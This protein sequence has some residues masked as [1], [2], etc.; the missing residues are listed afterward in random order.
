MGAVAVPVGARATFR[1]QRNGWRRSK[2]M[3]RILLV[4][5][6]ALALVAAA[7]AQKTTDAAAEARSAAAAAWSA[8]KWQ[9]ASANYRKVVEHDPKD[10]QAWHRLG[11]ALHA[12]GRL[13]EALQAHERTLAFPA[14]APTGAYNAACVYALKG[15]KDKAFEWLEKSVQRG[16]NNPQQFAGDRD[17]DSL[18]DD[19]RYAAVIAKV[20]ENAS[21]EQLQVFAQ[22]TERKRNRLV[23]FA[24]NRSPGQLSVEYGAVPWQAKFAAMVDDEST[25][26]RKWRLGADFWT[27]LDTSLPMT[28]GG[29]E[30]APG[31]YYLTLERREGGAFVLALHDAAKVKQR[32]LDAFVAHLLKGGIEVPMQHEAGADVAERLSIEFVLDEGQD[33]G[34]LRIAFG[35]HRLAAKAKVELGQ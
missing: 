12:Q 22:T 25:L 13:D 9:A 19:P 20:K 14:F 31:Y 8:Q 33:R 34:H 28:V 17:L 15:D 3:R 10:G 29:T 35:P 4:P 11:Y 16:M 21:K 30:I 27:S 5:F 26:G 7:F 24:N 2:P 18:R 6:C 23:W 32:K 1:Q